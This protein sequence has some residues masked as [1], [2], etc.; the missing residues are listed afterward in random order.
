[1]EQS[2]FLIKIIG[3]LDCLYCSESLVSLPDLSQYVFDFLLSQSKPPA[4][5]DI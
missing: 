4:I 1:M 2:W 5:V 3:G